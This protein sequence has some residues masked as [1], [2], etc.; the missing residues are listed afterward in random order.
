MGAVMAEMGRLA[1]LL[2]ALIHQ[3]EWVEGPQKGGIPRS[4]LTIG[5]TV[6][7]QANVP[8][9]F[10]KTRDGQPLSLLLLKDADGVPCWSL[11]L[12]QAPPG[13]AEHFL[14]Q[15]TWFVLRHAA[16]GAD[17]RTVCVD[18]QRCELASMQVQPRP[19][20]SRSSPTA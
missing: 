15:E 2:V 14:T 18:K 13:V 19:G 5:N 12:G 7:V 8:V 1:S 9:G 17:E 3:C 20:R 6:A 4:A 11:V 16:I 10:L